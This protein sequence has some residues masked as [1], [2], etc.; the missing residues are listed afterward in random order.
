[1]ILILWNA[2]S[3]NFVL[4]RYV[5][6]LEQIVFLAVHTTMT[7]VVTK[8]HKKCVSFIGTFY[9]YMQIMFNFRTKLFN[10]IG[11]LF[12]CVEDVYQICKIICYII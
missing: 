11:K 1:M 2:K 4:I 9:N 7:V 8:I 5:R 10:N 6:G 3:D 12:S